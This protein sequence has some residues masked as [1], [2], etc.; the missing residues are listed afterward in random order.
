MNKTFLTIAQALLIGTL[1]SFTTTNEEAPSWSIDKSHSKIGFEVTHFFTPVEGF[2]N[3]YEGTLNF[4]PENLE[5]S[6][7]S[8][9]VKVASVKTDS[10]KRDKDL[11]SGNFFNAAKFPEM[12]LVSTGFEKNNDGY[13]V[14]GNLTIR[15]VTKAVE[16]PF[17]V[18]GIGAHPMK[19]GKIL[20][21]IR[22]GLKI[23][24]NDYGV[25]TGNWAA[26]AVVGDEV[27]INIIL[28]ANRKG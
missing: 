22:G 24:R 14:K 6:S 19:K 4:D 26:T 11:Q 13:V 12:K 20:L 21:A 15:D 16:I 1:L 18:L 25:G 5:G 23:N 27:M 7:A 3:E 17:N 28:E 8:F 9:T 2:F 10:E